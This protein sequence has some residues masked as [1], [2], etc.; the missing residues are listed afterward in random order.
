MRMRYV[1]ERCVYTWCMLIVYAYCV[2]ALCMCIVFVYCVYT[3]YIVKS[4]Y[5]LYFRRD[6]AGVS[7]QWGALGV[8]D[9][10]LDTGTGAGVRSSSLG[11]CV[12]LEWRLLPPGILRDICTLGGG[13][14]AAWCM[15]VG[16]GAP[17]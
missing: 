1:Y 12:F 7:L 16:P 14:F 4:F 8:S 10:G 15:G 9:P 11:S 2:Y 13:K 17:I 5:S 6:S 3:Y